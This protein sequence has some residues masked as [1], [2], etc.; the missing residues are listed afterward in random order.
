MEFGK[1]AL[2]TGGSTGIGRG[3]VIRLAAIGYDV[4]FTHLN[5][6]EAAADV[7]EWIAREYGRKSVVIQGDLADP[8]T[9]DRYWDEAVD[10]FGKFDVVINNAGGALK[11]NITATEM[12]DMQR[13]IQVN[14][15]SGIALIRRAALSMI[16]HGIA[17]SIVSI[18]SS[19]AQ[20]AYPHDA[21][22]GGQKAALS[23]ASES[24]A[25]DL[26]PYGIR[27]NCV[28]PGAI[29]TERASAEYREKFGRKIPLGRMGTPGDI[30]NAVA[31][32]CSE[33]A[34][35]IT[36]ITLRVD[37]GLILPGMPENLSHESDWG[38]I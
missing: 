26:A 33:E 24:M 17:G 11:K 32:L 10:A 29:A 30:A 20:R 37:G 28:A 21:I 5:E 8:A 7:S 14:F 12:H 36:G 9:P 31:W 1:T 6:P 18:S 25:L 15:T 34:S 2:V 16:E 4:A 22:Y 13:L 38:Q 23:R 35:Y 3:I 27:V 19:R